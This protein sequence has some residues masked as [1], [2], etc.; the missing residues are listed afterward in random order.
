[1]GNT[2][3]FRCYYRTYKKKILK[4]MCKSSKFFAIWASAALFILSSSSANAGLL[5][6]Y[7][8]GGVL[9]QSAGYIGFVEN[10][11]ADATI[12]EV[13]DIVYF[14]QDFSSIGSTSVPVSGAGA[15]KSVYGI[16]ALTATA[17]TDLSNAPPNP[18]P[19]QFKSRMEL[20][21]LGGTAFKDYLESDLGISTSGITLADW[22]GAAFALVSST[23]DTA[24]LSNGTTSFN[25]FEADLIAGFDGGSEFAQ[26]QFSSNA[27]YYGY[28]DKTQF[29]TDDG[30][31]AFNFRVGYSV[32]ATDDAT[33][34]IGSTTASSYTANGLSVD[35]TS[36]SSEIL[37]QAQS[38][39]GTNAYDGSLSANMVFAST[40][41]EPNTML[42]F[43]AVAFAGLAAR[44]RRD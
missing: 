42:V 44:R 10:G 3:C 5:G 14:I 30:D 40:V 31:P 13:G 26:S 20:G 22:G 11:T 34:T 17:F 39:S 43:S 24:L 28:Y 38:Y 37:T 4:T 36:Q 15:V 8:Q 32:L 21:A 35:L 12:F 9:T 23:T 33:V 6:D 25:G 29:A 18:P 2:C 7:F 41:P 1:V 27:F 19:Y 16:T